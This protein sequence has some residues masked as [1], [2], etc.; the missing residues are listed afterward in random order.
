M[1]RLAACTI[2]LLLTI[3]VASPSAVADNRIANCSFEDVDVYHG[4]TLNNWSWLA[5]HNAPATCVR[6]EDVSSRGLHSMRLS[7]CQ[8][9][10]KTGQ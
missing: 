8:R 4:M 2:A 9:S 5:W 3:A 10:V 6:D 1:K 7:K